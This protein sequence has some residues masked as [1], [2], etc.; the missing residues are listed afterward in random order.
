MGF[1]E[2]DTTSLSKQIKHE[3]CTLH[4]QTLQQ[5]QSAKYLCCVEKCKATCDW[6]CTGSLLLLAF[7][8]W[9]RDAGQNIR[10]HFPVLN[11]AQDIITCI[12]NNLDWGQMAQKVLLGSY[13]S[14]G[15]RRNLSLAPREAKE[16]RTHVRPKLEYSAQLQAPRL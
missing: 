4:N 3:Y 1:H 15:F 9:Y 13:K 2:S 16:Y 10:Y 11:A 7:V 12:S 5:V 6:F 14:L 8:I